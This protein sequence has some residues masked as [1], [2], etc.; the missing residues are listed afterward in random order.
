MEVIMIWSHGHDIDK[1]MQDF[2]NQI[3]LMA[4][5]G[6]RVNGRLEMRVCDDVLIVAQQMVKEVAK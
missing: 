4:D 3:Q 6:F 5:N 1:V 2:E